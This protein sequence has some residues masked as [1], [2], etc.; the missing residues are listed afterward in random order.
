MKTSEKVDKIHEEYD[1]VLEIQRDGL[2]LDSTHLI[3]EKL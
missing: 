1:K 2:V 3:E